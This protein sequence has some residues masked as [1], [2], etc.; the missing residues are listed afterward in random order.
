MLTFR[1]K[2]LSLPKRSKRIIMLLLDV[3][4]IWLSVWIGFV[5]RLGTSGMHNPWHDYTWLY[6]CAPLIT[7]PV[8]IR[9]GLYR[10]VLRYFGHAAVI[11]ILKATVL[12]SLLLALIVYWYQPAQIVPRSF[13]LNYWVTLFILTGGVRVL[14]RRYLLHNFSSMLADPLGDGVVSGKMARVAIYGAGHAGRQLLA[15][16]RNSMDKIPVA[17]IDDDRSIANRVIDGLWVYRPKHVEQMIQETRASELFLAIPS[18]HPQRRNEIISLLEPYPVH[19]KTVPGIDEIVS[20][21]ASISELR[22]IDIEDLLGRDVVPPVKTLLSSCIFDKTV[23]VTG[24]GG[25]IGSEL[26][27]QILQLKPGRLILFELSEYALYR[28]EHNLRGICET[29]SI[30]VDIQAFLGSVED[31]KLMQTLFDSWKVNTVYHAAAYKHVPIV[32]ENVVAGIHNNLLGTYHTALAAIS[33]Q[34]ENF[35]LISTDKAVRPTN[36]MGASKR[37]AELV[38]QGLAQ[39]ATGTIFTMVRFGNVL[40]SSGSVVPK[41]RSQ[42]EKRGPVTV[43]HP[44]VTRYFMTVEEAVQLVIQAGSLGSG[45]DVFV[46]DMGEPVKIADLAR[47]M[48]HLYG[49]TVLDQNHPDGD[50][51]IAYTGLRPGEKLF[52]EL[53]VGADISGTEHPRIMRAREKCIPGDEIEIRMQQIAEA[54]VRMDAAEII[55][56]LQQSD[57]EYRP[58]SAQPD[59]LLWKEQNRNIEKHSAKPEKP[60]LVIASQNGDIA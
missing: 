5:L 3:Q 53:L 25:S 21:R 47:R 32:E 29:Q 23:M 28:I 42:I 17:F 36:V 8:F 15:A 22:E 26:C 52:E 55:R 50:I 43:T 4:L 56:L 30:E 38:L 44:E 13:V 33:A 7:L 1:R 19:V 2:L 49:Y 35:V 48:I 59:D 24:A 37:F 18:L 31:R 14:I 10:A 51:E 11:A 41:F 60:Y 45:G 46:L 54:C 27:R 12:S 16:L 40:G 58:L 9:L 57:L 34:V 20:G 39:T 6:I